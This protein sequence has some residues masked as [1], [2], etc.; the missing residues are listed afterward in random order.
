MYLFIGFYSKIYFVNFGTV[1][2]PWFER[3]SVRR[4]PVRPKN[5]GS[6]NLRF[7]ENES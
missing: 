3:F 1:R 7:F 4:E 5:D 2:G 6:H